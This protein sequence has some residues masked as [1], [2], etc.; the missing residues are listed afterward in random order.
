MIEDVIR[1]VGDITPDKDGGVIKAVI[2]EP[3]TESEEPL[4]NDT[5]F[6]HYSG[7][8]E[9][10]T[11][12]DSSVARNEPFDFKLSKGQVIKGWELG[13]ATMRTGEKARF[14]IKPEYG[15]GSHGSGD[16]IP[17]NSTLIFDVELLAIKGEDVSHDKD[18]SV[19]KRVLLSG[20]GYEHPEDGTR[21]HLKDIRV[22]AILPCNK[23]I[24]HKL[25]DDLELVIGEGDEV[26]IPWALEWALIKMLKGERAKI[27][28]TKIR[29]GE[30]DVPK[31]TERLL[32]TLTLDSFVKAKQSWQMND[33]EKIE[34]AKLQ[35]EKGN[36]YFKQSK[37]QQAIER[38]KRAAE[39]APITDDDCNSSN[40]LFTQINNNLVMCYLKNGD[41]LQA[42][43]CA[44]KILEKDPKNEKALFRRG[45]AKFARNDYDDALT[46][47]HKVLEVNSTNTAASSK[48]QS[49]KCCM[50]QYR[51]K[52]KNLFAKM[53]KGLGSNDEHDQ[54]KEK[55]NKK[56]EKCCANTHC[57]AG[58]NQLSGCCASKKGQNNRLT[59]LNL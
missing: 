53:M 14:T 56:K 33:E 3:D 22:D 4:P 32:Y 31:E 48:I 6:V 26:G 39:C 51:E 41:F 44:D 28:L 30:V 17:G 35:K 8:L 1:V 15:Y 27:Q 16:K 25:I 36:K 52:E 50:R 11:E 38:Y 5:V 21:V 19:I 12:F 55:C 54:P 40:Q 37:F 42:I 57:E 2:R 34:C 18:E 29:F 9:D 23:L 47:F 59:S 45:E 43:E 49:V 58:D 24:S 13:V 10:G 46:D 20:E 7:K